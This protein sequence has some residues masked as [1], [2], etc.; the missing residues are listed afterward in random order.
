MLRLHVAAGILRDG[1]GRVLITERLC[2]GP[3][4]GLWEF[5]GG[6]ITD[7]ETP[8][9][10]LH[11]ELAEELGV[12][13]VQVQPFMELRHEYPD[14]AVELEF[15]VVS[16]WQG[17]PAGLEGQRIRWVHPAELDAEQLLPAD[18]P[19]VTALQNP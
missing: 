7:G 2:D 10:A 6:K 18:A 12:A 5:P 17:E 11:R 3:F 16:A 19:V 9:Q 13:A 1:A 15:F 8:L 14:R 4:N